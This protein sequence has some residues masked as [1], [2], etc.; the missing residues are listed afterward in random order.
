MTT[1]PSPPLHPDL[2][3]LAFLL[4]TWSG[5][6]HGTY[7]TIADF[8]YGE[9]I[10]FAHSGKTFI[11]YRQRTWE[12]APGGRPLHTET[13]YWRPGGP[14][15]VEVMLAQPTGIVELQEGTVNGTRIALTSTFVGL[16]ST[17]K[18]VTTLERTLAVEG[19]ELRYRLLMG[20]VGQPHQVHL[21]AMLRRSAV[22]G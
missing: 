5:S 19:D 22:T 8:D 15:R 6:G 18:E 12:A 17:A 4:G 21:E 16:A 10:T 20:A 1:S 3:P 9:E 11:L 7:P 14:G 2:Q 13:G